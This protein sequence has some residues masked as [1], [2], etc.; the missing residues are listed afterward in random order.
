MKLAEKR[1]GCPLMG[2]SCDHGIST[3]RKALCKLL[4]MLG[5]FAYLAMPACGGWGMM[6]FTTIYAH[7]TMLVYWAKVDWT[8]S[9]H[10][11]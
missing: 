2:R 5:H 1:V 3:V 4:F 7:S 10:M 11:R 8:N 9:G 6:M